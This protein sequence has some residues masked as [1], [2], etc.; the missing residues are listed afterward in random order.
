M[1]WQEYVFISNYASL[2]QTRTQLHM[3]YL[4]VVCIF[5]NTHHHLHKALNLKTTTKMIYTLAW[6]LIQV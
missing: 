5:L 4:N 6:F 3:C 2:L 1:K